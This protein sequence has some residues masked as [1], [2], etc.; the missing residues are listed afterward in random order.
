MRVGRVARNQVAA[1]ELGVDVVD[2]AA[3][4]VLRHAPLA[5]AERDIT[6][7]APTGPSQANPFLGVVDPV[8][9]GRHEAIESMFGIAGIVGAD[10]SLL[11]ALQVPGA[12]TAQ[13]DLALGGHEQAIHGP[14]EPARQNQ[15]FE[16]NRPFIHDAIAVRVFEHGDRPYGIFLAFAFYIG[17]EPAHLA[18][19]DA[20]VGIE[21][22]GHWVMN[23]R[24]AGHKLDSITGDNPERLDFLL[25]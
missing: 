7:P 24:L 11:V 15:A 2:Q 6:Y 18:H 22:H 9:E 14:A 19:P 10:E 16:E 3:E 8:I 25:R 20:A 5:A 1:K 17:H 4:V 21:R 12:I 13:P 23:Q